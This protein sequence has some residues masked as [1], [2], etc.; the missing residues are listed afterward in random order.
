MILTEKRRPIDKNTK[1]AVWIKYMG[2]KV[3]GKCCCCN[4]RTIHITDFQVG[5]NK[6]V[7]RGGNDNI[8]N[9]RPICGPCNRGMG[10]MSIDKYREK[11]FVGQS[12]VS[13]KITK[14]E[15]L[16]SLP[17][18]KLEKLTDKFGIELP[19]FCMYGKDDYVKALMKYRDV[20]VAKIQE[21]LKI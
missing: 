12:N 2:N 20:T 14:R 11:Y 7:A 1:D 17:I 16:E 4:I 19:I 3:E 9:L 18:T 13:K 21:I 6:A 8:I 15:L 5:H 10:T